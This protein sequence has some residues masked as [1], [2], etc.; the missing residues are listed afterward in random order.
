MAAVMRTKAMAMALV[1]ITLAHVCASA[2]MGYDQQRQRVAELRRSGLFD[3]NTTRP[4]IGIYTQDS[5][6]SYDGIP[7]KNDE[8]IAASY[9]KLVESAGARPVPVSYN[10]EKY[11]LLDTLDI[12]DGFIFPGGGMDLSLDKTY[13]RNAMTI[14]NYAQDRTDF[15][16][17]GI[18]L[19]F[20]LISTVVSQDNTILSSFDSS[21]LLEKPEWEYTAYTNSKL[22]QFY[23]PYSEL[24]SLLVFENHHSGVSI[25][26]FES[27]L[28]GFFDLLA[29]GVDRNG[30]KY[31]A[32]ME[33]KDYLIFGFQFHPEKNT[34]E[35]AATEVIPHD[36]WDLEVTRGVSNLLAYY[37]RKGSSTRRRR[38]VSAS[39]VNAMVSPP[40]SKPHP[41]P[42][43]QRDANQTKPD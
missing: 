36:Y 25:A 42:E 34:Y 4:L 21:N 2:C 31:V 13:A 26:R 41:P 8:Y 18:C 6:S 35:W 30:S 32:A 12:L 37:S 33:A 15:L 11:E 10:L 38:Q 23:P 16:V 39:D 28:S 29:T 27:E 24:Q 3:G 5:P 40:H 20:Q 7:G 19:G 9:A 17:V 22:S 43:R 1:G 14:V